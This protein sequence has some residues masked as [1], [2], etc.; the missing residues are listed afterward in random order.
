MKC[1]EAI[2]SALGEEL[3]IHLP[4]EQDTEDCVFFHLNDH[5]KVIIF[6][7]QEAYHVCVTALYGKSDLAVINS[8]ESLPKAIDR[9]HKSLIG[10][11]SGSDDARMTK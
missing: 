3:D 1:V 6:V 11:N 9:L 8:S 10:P 7:E 5:A 2:R 4:S